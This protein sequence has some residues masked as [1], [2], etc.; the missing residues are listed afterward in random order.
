MNGRH[1][2]KALVSRFRA[3]RESELTRLE[4]KL[5]GLTDEDRKSVEAI[6]AHVVEAIAQ[7]PQHA[8]H[9]GASQEAVDALVHLFNLTPVAR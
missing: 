4:K 6:T 7:V 1:A 3:I 9:L 5:R 2:G 8:L